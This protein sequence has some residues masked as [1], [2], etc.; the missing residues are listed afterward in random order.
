MDMLHWF[1][2]IITLN[3]FIIWGILL[4]KYWDIFIWANLMLCSF[5]LMN[6]IW[7][8]LFEK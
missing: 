2:I 6:Y 8:D 5:M 1:F 7:N 4:I 3:I